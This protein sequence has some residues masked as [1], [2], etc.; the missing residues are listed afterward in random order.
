MMKKFTSTFLVSSLLTRLTDLL[1]VTLGWWLSSRNV[2]DPTHLD[3]VILK[4]S[5]MKDASQFRNTWGPNVT[6]IIRIIKCAN[7]T[8][9]LEMWQLWHYNRDLTIFRCHIQSGP[10]EH[11]PAYITGCYSLHLSYICLIICRW[12]SLDD[13]CHYDAQHF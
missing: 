9:P 8:E 11:W 1:N 7:I 2:M 6:R 10:I 3:G 5:M 13:L 12:S 4:E